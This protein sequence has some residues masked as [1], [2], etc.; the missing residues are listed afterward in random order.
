MGT[1]VSGLLENAGVQGPSVVSGAGSPWIPGPSEP[2]PKH[3]NPD[4]QKAR[5]VVPDPESR[6]GHLGVLLQ[7]WPRVCVSAAR[8]SSFC[9]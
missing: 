6:T 9:L 1:G 4:V 2:L 5:H 8:W 3:R 7:P